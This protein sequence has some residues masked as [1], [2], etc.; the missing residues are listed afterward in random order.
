MNSFGA[1]YPRVTVWSAPCIRCDAVRCSE[2]K[3]HRTLWKVRDPSQTPDEET[4]CW[5]R[6]QERDAAHRVPLAVP[7]WRGHR[8]TRAGC[9]QSA[10]LSRAARATFPKFKVEGLTTSW[11]PPV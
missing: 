8:H 5:E 7:S 3:L 1:R 6:Q 10:G 2:E 4:T 9:Y 11:L